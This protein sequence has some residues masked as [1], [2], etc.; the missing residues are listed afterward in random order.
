MERFEPEAEAEAP[1]TPEEEENA[2]GGEGEEGK[3]DEDAKEASFESIAKSPSSFFSRA[4]LY[5]R[6]NWGRRLR[7]KVV[8]PEPRK[9]VRIVMGMGIGGWDI[10]FG[11]L[12]VEVEGGSGIVGGK[13][14]RK[15]GEEADGFGRERGMGVDL[16]DCG[17]V[18]W[19]RRA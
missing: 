7:I 13:V 16:A 11:R 12:G 6:G 9:P 4:S 18:I 19:R 15:G 8:L 2:E 14:R 5:P 3:K 1:G 10:D 17:F